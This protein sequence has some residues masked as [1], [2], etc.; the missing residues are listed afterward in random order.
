VLDLSHV[1]GRALRGVAG[2]LILILVGLFVLVRREHWGT[3]R[4]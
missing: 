4:D 3:R 1:G 2:P